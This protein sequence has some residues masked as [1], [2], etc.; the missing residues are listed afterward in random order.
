MKKLFAII[1]AFAFLSKYSHAAENGPVATICKTEIE[2]FCTDKEHVSKG[3]RNCLES[4]KTTLSKECQ[5]ILENTGP[6]KGAGQGLKKGK[7]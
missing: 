2:K 7:K 5:Q 6:G 1:A 3:V 4:N